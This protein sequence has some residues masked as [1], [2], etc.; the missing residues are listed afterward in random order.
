M[1]VSQDACRPASRGARGNRRRDRPAPLG[2][3]R[4]AVSYYAVRI[5]SPTEI[6]EVW[7]ISF[8]DAMI[9]AAGQKIAGIEIVSPFSGD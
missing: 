3:W 5:E 8:W 6:G 4:D 2:R 1:K 9:L 7:Q